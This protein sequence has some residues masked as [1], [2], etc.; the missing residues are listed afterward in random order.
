MK[1]A[2]RYWNVLIF[3]CLALFSGSQQR[4][5]E[6]GLKMQEIYPLLNPM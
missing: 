4:E 5:D 6:Q 2:M 1:K 3:L